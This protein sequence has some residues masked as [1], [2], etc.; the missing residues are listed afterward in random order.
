MTNFNRQILSFQTS[1]KF[2][3]RLCRSVHFDIFHSLKLGKIKICAIQKLQNSEK[4][5]FFT[6]KI[7]QIRHSANYENTTDMGSGQ[8]NCELT[9]WKFKDFSVIQI[10]REINFRHFEAPKLPF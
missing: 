5:Q 8:A 4:C 6:F 3:I 1:S 10:F 7:G 2:Q 9:V